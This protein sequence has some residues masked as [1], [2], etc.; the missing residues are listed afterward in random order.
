MTKLRMK[1]LDRPPVDLGDAVAVLADFVGA[2]EGQG[3]ENGTVYYND[4]RGNRQVLTT[5]HLRAVHARL[6]QAEEALRTTQEAGRERVG[7]RL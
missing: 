2:A 3:G 5:D 7:S 6:V 1:W 4:G